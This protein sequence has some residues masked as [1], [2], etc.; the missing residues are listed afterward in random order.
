MRSCDFT[1]TGIRRAEIAERLGIS[2]A[3]VYCI[4]IRKRRTAGLA[5]LLAASGH[6]RDHPARQHGLLEQPSLCRG[7]TAG[8]GSVRNHTSPDTQP[9]TS[10]VP[11]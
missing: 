6:G 2:E 3:S 8:G 1:A 10:Y 5:P 4:A 11:H 9:L 7:A